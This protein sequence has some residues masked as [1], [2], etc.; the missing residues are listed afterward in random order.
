MFFKGFRN[1]CFHFF[2][3]D[4]SSLTIYRIS[5]KKKIELFNPLHFTFKCTET[6]IV[7]YLK[8]HSSLGVT[9]KHLSS[10]NAKQQSR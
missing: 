9:Q 10:A 1:L 6:Y 7:K 4:I 5:V 2:K 3:K 8:V